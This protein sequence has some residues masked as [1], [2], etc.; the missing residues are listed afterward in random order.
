LHIAPCHT[1]YLSTSE[2][3]RGSQAEEDITQQLEA[4]EVAANAV[5]RAVFG[6]RGQRTI[7][8]RRAVDRGSEES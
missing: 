3:V 6:S 7:G 8:C 4:A 1:S 2:N 5:R